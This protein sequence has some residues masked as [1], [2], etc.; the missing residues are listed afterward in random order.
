MKEELSRGQHHQEKSGEVSHSEYIPLTPEESASRVESKAEELQ[1][2]SV[3][4][5]S[6]ERGIETIISPEKDSFTIRKL[7]KPYEKAAKRTHEFMVEQF[8]KE[9]SETLNWFRHTIKEGIND[10]HAMEQEGEVVAFSNTRCLELEPQEGRPQ[11]TILTIW[12]IAANEELRQKGLGR[13]L[14][15][16]FYRDAAEKARTNNQTLL[17]VVGEVVE[18]AEPFFNRI[19][20]KRTYYEDAEGNVR[21][22]PYQCP[23]VDM[24]SKTGEPLEAPVPEHMMVWLADNRQE[25]PAE[26]LLRMV[27]AIYFREYLGATDDYESPEA[28][29]RARQSNA[30]LLGGIRSALAEAKDGKVFFMSRQER[31]ARRE[32]LRKQGKDVYDTKTGG[33]EG[34]ESER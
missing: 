22:V 4:H 7:T 21:E 3:F 28:Y 19:G 33:E 15:Q 13:E 25:I 1:A 32:M 9:E 18:T 12:H 29:A 10:Y 17:G 14:C 30:D 31:E 23:P 2:A 11:E 6:R 8:G 5:R 27:E 24:D 16:S 34:S 20:K 26:D